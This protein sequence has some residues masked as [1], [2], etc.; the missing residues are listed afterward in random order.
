MLVDD[1]GLFRATLARYLASE[2]DF[3]VTA[4]CGT[5]AEALELLR[6]ARLDLVLL[7]CGLG[8]DPHNEFMATARENGY[9]GRFLIVCDTT[10]ARSAASALKF[11]ASGIFLKSEPPDRLVRVI[12]L[13]ANG[14]VWVDPKVIQMLADKLI[15]RRTVLEHDGAM[16]N[17]E[18]REREVLLG[19][20]EGL[21]NRKIG[22][23]LG[24][25]ESSVKNVVQR[26]FG[27]AGVKTRS[28]LVRVALEGPMYAMSDLPKLRTEGQRAGDASHSELDQPVSASQVNREQTP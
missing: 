14:E 24:L 17:L 27:K 9:P 4:E 28:Q 15:D 21:P 11:G 12:R 2:R 8:P 25:S 16:A 10:D 7:S 3:E 23:H 22:D 5:A 6:S 18:P 1:H 20:L 19:I 13:V 26:L